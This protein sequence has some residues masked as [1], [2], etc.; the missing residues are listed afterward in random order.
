MEKKE[1]LNELSECYDFFVRETQDLFNQ[2]NAVLKADSRAV[3]KYNKPIPSPI[4]WSL[5]IV[6]GVVLIAPF[7]ILF[8]VFNFP[9]N[10]FS[11]VMTFAIVI[12]FGIRIPKVIHNIVK[13]YKK[14]E[15]AQKN[16]KLEGDAIFEKIIE[17]YNKYPEIMGR[18]CILSIDYIEPVFIKYIY[19]LIE[20]GRADT[21]KEALNI[22]ENN[23]KMNEIN[24]SLQTQLN[25]INRDLAN[26]QA[27]AKNAEDM[28]SLAMW[29]SRR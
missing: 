24:N 11:V 22:F 23:I 15:E 16:R 17:K 9:I 20:S 28:A 27:S 26:I 29:T 4:F 13:P 6:L 5:R 19:S 10:G 1:I 3:E 18:E 8:E 21:I 7:S 25:K 12:F 14:F 2:Y